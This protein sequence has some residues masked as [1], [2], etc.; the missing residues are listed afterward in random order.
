MWLNAS[1]ASLKITENPDCV[2]FLR[3]FKLKSASRLFNIGRVVDHLNGKRI[4]LSS[5]T[6]QLWEMVEDVLLNYAKRNGIF[7]CLSQLP[8]AIKIC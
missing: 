4:K 7:L 1:N 5:M 2:K 6:Q 3:S 8:L